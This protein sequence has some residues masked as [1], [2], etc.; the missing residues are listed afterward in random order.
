MK[1]LPSTFY[2]GKNS[3]PSLT[4]TSTERIEKGN[5]L[6]RP[7]EFFLLLKPLIQIRATAYL[8]IF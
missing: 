7:W 4:S 5:N 1:V 6:E 3:E 8:S 2:T